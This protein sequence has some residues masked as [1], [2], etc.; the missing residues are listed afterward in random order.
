M[1]HFVLLSGSAILIERSYPPAP[2]SLSVPS[3]RSIP[4]SCT[5]TLSLPL[6]P[7]PPLI[8]FFYIIT[9]GSL[10]GSDG[11]GAEEGL[12]AGCRLERVPGWD[13]FSNELHS[14]GL[15]VSVWGTPPFV[16]VGSFPLHERE[17]F[18]PSSFSLLSSLSSLRPILFSPR[19]AFDRESFLLMVTHARMLRRKYCIS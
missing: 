2:R 15:C 19:T 3:R 7:L 12:S 6:P 1:F 4:S 18:S 9:C 5:S 8:S 11:S 10:G 17:S 14:L 13:C 16:L